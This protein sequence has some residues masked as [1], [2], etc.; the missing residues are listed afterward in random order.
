MRT[1]S[2]IL[3]KTQCCSPFKSITTTVDNR[4]CSTGIYSPGR[5]N[6]IKHPTL[7]PAKLVPRT[8]SLWIKVKNA[9]NGG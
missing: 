6:T 5:Q 8:T 1:Y 9:S 2:F 3:F 7:A 4:M